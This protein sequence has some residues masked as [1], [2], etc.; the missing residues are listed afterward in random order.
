MGRRAAV[1][2]RGRGGRRQT[3]VAQKS[4]PVWSPSR[5][6]LAAGIL[7]SSPATIRSPPVRFR[8]WARSRPNL[9]SK[10]AVVKGGLNSCQRRCGRQSTSVYLSSYDEHHMYLACPKSQ[11][12]WQDTEGWHMRRRL[13]RT[14]EK[15]RHCAHASPRRDEPGR[16]RAELIA[17][18]RA[19]TDTR[20]KILK[21][22][23]RANFGYLD[24]HMIDEN[25]LN[26]LRRSKESA[27][28]KSRGV[29]STRR[30]GNG[31]S[32]KISDSR[33]LHR[34]ECLTPSGRGHVD[35]PP[36][37][38]PQDLAHGS[39]S[40]PPQ[41]PA[42]R[43]FSASELSWFFV[44]SWLDRWHVQEMQHVFWNDGHHCP[45][46]RPASICHSGM[47]PR[48]GPGQAVRSWATVP[49]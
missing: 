49:R 40:I 37:A 24:K 20:L 38:Q 12:I 32:T 10:P 6:P 21:L 33:E 26:T 39:C 36:Q 4:G 45:Q 27:R 22:P 3:P 48:N 34:R 35:R 1:Q 7:W 11:K 31:D 43:M 13:I 17:S 2:V 46:T 19:V 16:R 42:S 14:Y 5:S 8:H 23:V 47:L 18:T 9:A 30:C 25:A 44:L 41:P 28:A 29:C 15:T